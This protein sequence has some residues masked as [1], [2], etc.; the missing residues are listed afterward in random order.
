[1][2][3]DRSLDPVHSFPLVM[4]AQGVCSVG[5]FVTDDSVFSLAHISVVLCRKTR[6]IP[7]L[8]PCG[9]PAKL[10]FFFI[11][12]NPVNTSSHSARFL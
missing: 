12:V 8:C 6:E 5:V 1:M 9:D 10:F 11:K 3:V 4:V 7:K 2:C